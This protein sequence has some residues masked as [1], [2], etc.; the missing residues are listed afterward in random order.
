MLTL[1]TFL[2]A[3]PR[4]SGTL[5]IEGEAG[6]GK[7]TLWE[8]GLDHA[9]AN[10]LWV[11][12]ARTGQAEAALAYSTLGDLLDGV[13]SS[14][15]DQLPPPQRSA[16]DIALLRTEPDAVLDARAVAVATLA[17]LRL[18]AAD[19]PSL[20]GLD[21]VQWLDPSSAR[22]IEFVLRRLSREPIGMIITRRLGDGPPAQTE[23]YGAVAPDRLSRL[24]VG[25]LDSTSLAMVIRDR[26]KCDLPRSVAVKIH[27]LSE[28]NPFYALEIGREI[29]R[30]GIPAAG[31]PFPV[32][33]D[34]ADVVRERVELLSD[35]A[36]AALRVVAAAA[37]PTRDMVKAT[38]PE[39]D[40]DAALDEA[41]RAGLVTV[42]AGR[43]AYTHPLFATAIS[44]SAMAPEARSVHRRLAEAV[45]DPEERARHLALSALGPDRAIAHALDAGALEARRRGAAAAAAELASL[46]QEFTPDADIAEPLRR[47]VIAAMFAF[48]AGDALRADDLLKG[49]IDATP[50]GPARAA[51]MIWLC[52]I[53]WQDTIRVERFARRALAECGAADA[54]AAGAHVMLA[55]TSMYQGHLAAAEPHAY[56]ARSLAEAAGDAATRSDAHTACA[57]T[58]FLAGGDYHRDISEAVLLQN[59]IDDGDLTVTGTVY[60]SARVVRGLLALW[61]GDLASARRHLEDELARYETL[62]RYVARDEVLCYLAQ[63]ECRSGNWKRAQAYSDECLEIGEE[64]GHVRGRGQNVMPRAWVAALRGDLDEA[65]TAAREGLEL[66]QHY[67]DRL[68]AAGNRGVLGFAH[69]SAGNPAAAAADLRPIIAFLREMETAEPGV[70]PFV[71]D[72]VEALIGSGEL[73]EAEAIVADDRL[74]GRVSSRPGWRSAALRVQGLVLA[75]RGDLAGALVALERAVGDPGVAAQPLELGRALLLKGEVERRTKH[76]ARAREDLEEARDVFEGLGARLWAERARTELARVTAPPATMSELSPTEQRLADLVAHGKTNREAADQLFVSVKTVEANLSRI[77]RKLGV[78]SRSELAARLM[79]PLDANG[80]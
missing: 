18:I 23:I 65:I 13:P 63:L 2:D 37:R 25:P 4:G 39:L 6:I 38:M 26:L 24:E 78:R 12:A 30:A 27:S 29:V 16:I 68:A 60:S 32:P 28:G 61:S 5:V 58:G 77:Y 1:T 33:E 51:V 22:V 66:S 17:V 47:T 74:M 11:A 9:R 49:A 75:A 76:R 69:L 71:G 80:R 21:D 35:T 43:V 52:E 57:M 36:I 31:Q 7:T 19:R 42:R 64:S 70:V 44:A 48:E 8:A 55:W 73:A 79:N 46:A 14:V 20:L 15:L 53:S 67:E 50:P 40:V 72:A 10:G 45:A 54:V 56:A 59:Q 34:A 3:V 62:G 41:E